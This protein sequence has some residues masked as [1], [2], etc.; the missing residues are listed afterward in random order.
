MTPE[1]ITKAKQFGS[2]LS[3]LVNAIELAENV[4]ARAAGAALA[5]AQTHHH[6]IVVLL[7]HGL[8]SSAMAL[9]RCVVDAYL[10][11]AWLKHCATD[12]EVQDCFIGDKIFPKNACLMAALEA[13]PEFE[14][15]VFSDRINKEVWG[16]MC[17]FIHTGSV[18]LQRWQSG[19]S[20]EQN[21][22]SVEIEQCLNNT[23]LFAA[24]SAIEL[25]HLSEAPNVGEAVLKLMEKRWSLK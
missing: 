8:H 17:D 25:V 19:N 21:F 14:G 5:I 23:E 12:A 3:D 1:R 11:G 2:E 18:H 22:N 7:E 9:Y 24:L 6:A 10:R 13:K 20:L 16:R 15:K 4:R